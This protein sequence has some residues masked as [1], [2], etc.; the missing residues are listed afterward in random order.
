MLVSAICVY[1]S[2]LKVPHIKIIPA[3]LCDYFIKIFLMVHSYIHTH[4]VY[5][6]MEIKEDLYP[7]V[8]CRCLYA[9][10]D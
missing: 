10:V 9:N 6:Y 3:I 5:M 1:V 8:F 7:F 2:L 4:T